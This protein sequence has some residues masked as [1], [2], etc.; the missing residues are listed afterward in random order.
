MRG[1]EDELNRLNRVILKED[2]PN[3]ASYDPIPE[4]RIDGEPGLEF[5]REDFTPAHRIQLVKWVPFT[6][7]KIDFL[8]PARGMKPRGPY[9]DL[10]N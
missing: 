7:M 6:E 2:E 9:P 8:E 3:K 1:I 10:Q 5:L 4:G